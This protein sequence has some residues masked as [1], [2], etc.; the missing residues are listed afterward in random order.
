[1]SDRYCSM[2]HGGLTLSF[3]ADYTF[4]QHCCLRS[5]VFPI[6]T[7]VDFWKDKQ[8]TQLREF[9]KTNQW[10][11]ECANCEQL[12][13]ANNVSF[14]QGMNSGL[15]I[16]G[17][18]DLTGP[19]RIDLMFDISCNLACRTCGP[20][21]STYWQRHLKQHKQWDEPIFVPRNK[22]QVLEALAQLDLS[23]LRQLVFCGGETLLGNEYWAVADWFAEH[24]PN[25]KQ[26]LT[27]CFQTNGT[28]RILPAHHSI[29][30]KFALVKLH[31][32]LDGVEDQFEYL[33]WPAV[34]TDTVTNL[35]NLKQELPS[36]VM[37]VIEE[38]VSIFNLASLDKLK[39]WAQSQFAV[40]R[41]GDATNHTRH[42]AKGMFG[43]HNCSAEYVE[44][45]HN[46]AYGNLIP[47]AWQ[48]NATDIEQ[49][50]AEIKR[51]DVLRDQ[52]FEAVFPDVARYYSRF[53]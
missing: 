43:L 39:R 41:E 14:R 29:I 2:I 19:A 36:N 34:W 44:A 5:T 22:E 8:F 6:D 23:N 52:S 3:K 20:G 47:A 40:N 31:V 45:M 21:S 24:V 53:L 16:Q 46:T 12:E 7:T 17:Q 26:Q 10:D 48:E 9:N 1:M 38:T 49:M 11:V 25:A 4:A 13:M 42:L 50:I 32:S 28:Q 15:G 27:L 37:F 33:R 18:T 51:F 35:M 30:E